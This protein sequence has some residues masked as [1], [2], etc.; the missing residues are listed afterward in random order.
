MYN[1]SKIIVGLIVFAGIVT[2]P[3][4]YNLGKVN[5][6]PEPKI[7][8]PV[9]QQL[10]EKNCIE[11]KEFMKA[12]HMQLLNKWRDMVV[13]NGKRVYVNSKGEKY[14]ISL[15]NTCLKCHSNKKEFCDECH[16]YMSVKTHCWNCHLESKG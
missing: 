11:S 2:F 5:A 1:G 3:F 16:N 15:Q 14:E 8:T 6:K 4:I 10:K 13:R 7:D 9:I 12:N